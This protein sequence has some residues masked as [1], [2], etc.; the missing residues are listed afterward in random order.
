MFQVDAY[1]TFYFVD[2]EGNKTKFEGDRSK[3]NLISFV[4]AHKVQPDKPPMHIKDE[5]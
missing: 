1:P 3:E 2:S 5:L 4:Q